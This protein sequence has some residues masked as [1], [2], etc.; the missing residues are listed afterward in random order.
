MSG[1]GFYQRLMLGQRSG[2]P[3]RE[4]NHA[5]KGGAERTDHAATA[6]VQ[7]RP[8]STAADGATELKL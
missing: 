3:E 7:S 5:A 6:G 1:A 4:S 8:P 2:K